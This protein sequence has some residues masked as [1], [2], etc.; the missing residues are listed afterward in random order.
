ML[1]HFTLDR[2]HDI[3]QRLDAAADAGC[4]AV[5][6][7]VGDYRRLEADG[8]ADRLVDM[9]DERNLCVGEIDALRDWAAPRSAAPRD[10]AENEATAFRIADRLGCRSLH[11]LPPTGT[12][13]ATTP[14]DDPEWVSHTASR[15]AG[16]CDR[17]AEHDLLVAIEFL[18][19]TDIADA[20]GARRVVEEADRS[21]GGLVLD[22]WHHERGARDLAMLASLSAGIVIDV[23]LSDGPLVPVLADYGEDTRRNRLPPGEGEMDL[24]GFVAA[25]RA[26]GTGAPWAI[27]VCNDSG[28]GTTAGSTAEWV[29]RCA[30]GLR[31]VLGQH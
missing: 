12:S 15:F 20:A 21:N 11:V 13:T 5:G 10:A 14:A 3:A 7:H 17:A 29:G 27:E 1:S 30:A 22:V 19:G 23:Q 2:H 28:P 18:P 25:V 26:T 16:L 8:T 9:L 31:S 4:S 6:T 24:T